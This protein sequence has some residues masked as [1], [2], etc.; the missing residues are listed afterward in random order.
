MEKE[1]KMHINPHCHFSISVIGCRFPPHET[2]KHNYGQANSDNS[3]RKHISFV[4]HTVPL[5]AIDDWYLTTWKHF[6]IWSRCRFPQTRS[7]DG[8]TKPSLMWLH[9]W[10][11]D[12]YSVIRDTFSHKI[13]L[14][15]FRHNPQ[16]MCEIRGGRAGT[17]GEALRYFLSLQGEW[18]LQ[19]GFCTAQ[20]PA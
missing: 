8:T 17:H 10:F 19:V 3:S 2:I 6:L 14:Q 7:T 20:G 16:I 12:C 15:H 5:E 11:G 18:Q 13:V 9:L 4:F 1:Q